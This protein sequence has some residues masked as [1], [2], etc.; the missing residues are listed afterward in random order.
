MT[1]NKIFGF[2]TGT[3]LCTVLLGIALS[4]A[5]IN[6]EESVYYWDFAA[7]F[8]MFNQQGAL[9]VESPSEWLSQLDTSIATEDYG[10]A[11][12]VP[13]MPFH[14][15]FG[16]SRLSFVAGI[17]AVYLV[18]AVLLIGRIS[19]REA[20]SET[21]SR[22]WIAVWIAAFLY[23]P[24]W[25]PTLR[26]MP[27]VAGCL[28]LT[29]AT[30]F[31][32]KSRFLT[33]E[34]V[35]SGISVG[36]CLWLAFMLRRWYAY[37]AIGITVS[38]AFFCLLR[39]ARDRDF[40]A[41]RNAALGGVCAV[42]LIAA[43]ALNFQLP[44][45]AKILQ[46][47]Y[48][49]LYSG[50]KTTFVTQLGGVGSRL[51]YLNWALIVVGLYI[52]IVRHNRFALFCAMASVLTFLAFIRTQDPE[53]HHSL[54]MFLWLFPAYAQAIVSIVSVPG[55]KSRWSTAAI[56]VVAGLA[57]LGTFFPAGRQLLS[58]VG[59]V[60]AREATLP[61]HLDNLPEYGRLIDDLIARM[62]PEDRFSV[63]ASGSVM[64]DA[65]LFGMNRDLVAHVGWI[66]QVDSRDRFQ[67]DALKSRYVVVTDRPVTHLQPGAQICV[68]IPN[69]H[70]LEG[71]GIGAAYRRIA[72]YRLSGGVV[73]YLY[74]QVRPVSKA[75]VD[76]LYA[77]FRKKYPDW[78]VPE[79]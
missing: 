60:F 17:V 3:Y 1:K 4:A 29:A 46:T 39:I 19:Y 45:I 56:A 42:F 35:I 50:Y 16:G 72:E 52:S 51:S 41:F 75:E 43:T 33:R 78:A 73:G 18:P 53:R 54:P 14:L 12:L 13:L 68:T 22:S 10:V 71:K 23:T 65:L 66:C 8:N 11:I 58:P 32:W 48:A 40:A 34:P 62:G 57:F 27:D 38:A 64:S 15:V 37:A 67:P 6:L 76:A 5:Y 9:L 20:V 47:S 36:A 61:L 2:W 77:E 26:G 59:F 31:L 49:D 63:F 79:W 69:Q 30:Y 24:F 74:E 25:A 70:I 55:L 7:Y 28:A 21:P 44:L